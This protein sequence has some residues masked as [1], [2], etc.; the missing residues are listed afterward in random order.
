M[1]HIKKG[2]RVALL[3]ENYFPPMNDSHTTLRRGEALQ[4]VMGAILHHQPSVIYL[5]PTKGV[6]INLL[7][8]IVMNNIPVRLV[9]P[10]KHFFTT[11]NREDK[12]VLDMASSVADKI[13]I[14]NEHKSDPLR[15]T[16]DWYEATKKAVDNSDFVIIAH[17]TGE[18]NESFDDLILRFK[19]NPKPVVAVGFD[20]EA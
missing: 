9:F 16:D 19:N 10:S 17:S 13:I 5:C 20:V 6:N 2:A 3:G 4:K 8:L 12:C 15:W 14:L 18:G 11:L 1:N 7:P